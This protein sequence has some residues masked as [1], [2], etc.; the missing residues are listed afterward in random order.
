M[1]EGFVRLL[2]ERNIRVGMAETIDACKAFSLLKIDKETM[3]EGLA[4]CLV[5]DEIDR[6]DFDRIFDLYF[7]N[8]LEESTES[9][10]RR[11]GE[12]QLFQTLDRQER[13]Q[14]RMRRD[15]TG[16]PQPRDQQRQWREVLARFGG[17]RGIGRAIDENDLE[18]AAEQL[19]E[20]IRQRTH[21]PDTFARMLRNFVEYLKLY[22]GWAVEDAAEFEEYLAR[23]DR[24]LSIAQR[25]YLE[26]FREDYPLEEL[27]SK[28]VKLDFENLEELEFNKYAGNL[29]F[30]VNNVERVEKTIKRLAKQLA[31]KLSRREKLADRG[32]INIRKSI[33]KSIEYGGVL[34]KLEYKMRKVQKPEIV[35]L[36]DVSGSCEWISDFFIT[37]MLGIKRAF[38]DVRGYIFTDHCWAVTK[39]LDTGMVERLFQEI[40]YWWDMYRGGGSS[41]ME[42]AFEDF[43]RK[44]QGHIT[45]K[46][47]VI[48][49]SDCRDYLGT[50]EVYG[51][52]RGYPRSASKIAKLVKM[53]KRLIILNPEDPRFWN[54]GDSVV[55][56]YVREGAEC[57]PVKNLKELANMVLLAAKKHLNPYT[58]YL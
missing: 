30:L 52:L 6:P 54:T 51:S 21:D 58:R 46:T 55:D 45:K 42:T 15:D 3:R 50:R 27:I 12:G 25:K 48:I 22:S 28:L 33:R 56:Y 53:S 10:R 9:Q 40:S 38:S 23:I 8:L 36:C 13:E 17:V 29:V 2:R 26:L 49:L 43:I 34:A 5:K 24:V 44:T 35:L 18:G 16:Q 19:M 20:R 14:E 7:C 32:K 11:A 57:Y 31:S 39:A 47:T 4:A 37:L 1:I 41:N